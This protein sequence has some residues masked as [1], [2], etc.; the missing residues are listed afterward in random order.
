M[1]AAS[2]EAVEGGTPARPR[3]KK[4]PRVLVAA[5]LVLVLIGGLEVVLR[6]AGMGADDHAVFAPLPD[7]E[8]YQILNAAYLER[9]FRYR[10]QPTPAF[11]PFRA[12]KEP[13]SFRVFV[14]GGSAAAGRRT[15]DVES[16]YKTLYT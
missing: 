1:T 10:L 2:T 13:G 8:A 3:P 9:Y 7:Q 11:T 6:A 5:G 12:E 16:Y 14:L 4:W 15:K